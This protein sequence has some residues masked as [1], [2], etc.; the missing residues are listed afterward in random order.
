LGAVSEISSAL[1]YLAVQDQG[2]I[3]PFDTYTREVMSLVYGKQ[4]FEEKPAYEIVMTWLL[5]PTAW[6]E[7]PIIEINNN[8]VKEALKLDKSKKY[9][10]MA[11]VLSSERLSLAMQE[12]NSQREA[13]VKLDPYH[14]AL[15]RL[16][17]QVFI[18]REIAQGRKPALWPPKEGSSTT[19]WLSVSEMTGPAQKAFIDVTRAFMGSLMAPLPGGG[20][21][22]AAKD[23]KT[24]VENFSSLARA[25]NQE[26]FPE[27]S[28]LDLE[29]SYNKYHPFRWAWSFY[30]LTV[31]SLLIGFFHNKTIYSKIAWASVFVGF[32][33]HALGFWARVTLSQRAPV[34][35]MYE[36]VVWVSFGAIFFAMI[37]EKIYKI[38]Y[39]LF[40]GSLVS[41]FCLLLSDS[42]PSVLDPTIQPLEPVLRSNFWLSTHVLIITISYAAFFLAFALGDVG[43]Y[44][45]IRGEKK[46]ENKIKQIVTGI[47]R[48][49]QVGVALLAPGII[50]GGVWAD[51]S[52]GRF[53]GWDPKETWALIALLGYLAVL[54]GRLAGLLK[55][56]GMIAGGVISFSL[57]IMAWYG[58]NYVLGAG[59]HSY[60]FGAG[61]LEYVAAFIFLHFLFVG[62]AAMARKAPEV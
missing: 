44:Y 9:F 53:W 49:M 21:S 56:F 59:L 22:Q 55:N 20:E 30:L 7:K 35:N 46:N 62:W 15:Q 32:A 61:G 29:V 3:K 36:T 51:Y 41:F 37:L 25:E 24:A 8:G 19:Q 42:A 10:S 43:L 6:Q 28:K 27:F 50:L 48:A 47:Y 18:F 14:Q 38:K 31:L 11:E 12:L 1:K 26:L 45:I 34:S 39:I 58:V 57:V 40:A 4:T 52:W 33:F 16:E 13:K 5:Y 54:H 60:G 2:R 23:L 17:N